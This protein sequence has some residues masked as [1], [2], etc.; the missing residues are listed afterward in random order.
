LEPRKQPVDSIPTELAPEKLDSLPS[1]DGRSKWDAF[2]KGRAQ[3][4]AFFG[5]APAESLYSCPRHGRIAPE[6]GSGLTDNEAYEQRSMGGGLHCEE[7]RPRQIWSVCFDV[8]SVRCTSE[9]DLATGP[10]GRG[11]VPAL[12]AYRR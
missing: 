12:L 1:S 6:G 8:A 7:L 5:L 4:T 3:P 11:S 2:Y 10:F 9:Q